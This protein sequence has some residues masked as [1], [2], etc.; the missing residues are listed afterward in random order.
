MHSIEE[1][2]SLG[3]KH[4][5]SRWYEHVDKKFRLR[6][7]KDFSIDIYKLYPDENQR[8]FRGYLPKL[9]EIEWVLGRVMI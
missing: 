3:F 6:Q 9:E 8:V 5:G 7:W 1:I 2:E 4:I